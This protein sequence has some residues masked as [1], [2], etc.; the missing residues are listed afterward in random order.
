MA[1]NEHHLNQFYTNIM[2]NN[3][4]LYK[5][6]FLVELVGGDELAK[7]TS[8][9]TQPTEPGSNITYWA[10]SGSIPKIS[11]T[12]GKAVYFGTEFRMPGVIKFTHTWPM[13]ILLDEDMTIY[14]L[15]TQW[16]KSISDLSLDGGGIKNVPNV[17]LR[18][19]LTNSDN[20][21]KTT[22][23]IVAGVWPKTIGE[24]SLQYR[25]GGGELGK[26]RVEFA[27]QYCYEDDTFDGSNDPMNA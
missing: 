9:S 4:M 23:F 2:Q 7:Y 12:K 20:S 14:D 26:C 21:Q 18:V 8:F 10:Q 25:E 6:Q 22:S 17:N 5:Y 15:M 24:I 16:R 19:S 3:A 27:F 1:N 13:E 11:I